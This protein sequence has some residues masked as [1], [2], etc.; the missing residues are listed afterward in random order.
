M[1]YR[2]I[3]TDRLM[4][5]SSAALIFAALVCAWWSFI[6]GSLVNPPIIYWPGSFSI[7]AGS[8][9]PGDVVQIRLVATKITDS[10]GRVHWTMISEGNQGSNYVIHFEVRSTS[11]GP[12]YSDAII[13][14]LTLPLNCPPGR[15]H[16]HGYAEYEAN[17]IRTIS[18]SMTSDS[19]EVLKDAQ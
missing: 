14:V 12:G 11:L 8:Y 13:P 7:V 17:P 2:E 3:I 19:F 1:R 5:T 4:R 18:I 10:R 9:R 15:Y 16:L 6:D